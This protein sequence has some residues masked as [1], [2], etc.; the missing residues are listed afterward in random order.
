MISLILNLNKEYVRSEKRLE[1]LV[2]PCED[3]GYDP[4][5]A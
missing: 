2:A 3:E 5:I 1:S 4:E